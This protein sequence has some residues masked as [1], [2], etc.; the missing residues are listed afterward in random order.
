MYRLVGDLCNSWPPHQR[1]VKK[2]VRNRFL[3]SCSFFFFEIFKKNDEFLRKFSKCRLFIKI[4]NWRQ[5]WDF[6]LFFGI[7]SDTQFYN[8]APKLD[9]ICFAVDTIAVFRRTNYVAI[10]KC[11]QAEDRLDIRVSE[12]KNDMP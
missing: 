1:I 4:K 12:V 2:V 9:E 7:R 5:F 10:E 11:Q 8:F 6:Q 3:E